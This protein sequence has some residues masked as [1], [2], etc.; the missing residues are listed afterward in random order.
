MQLRTLLTA[1][2]VNTAIK[3]YVQKRLANAEIGTIR[4]T[5][6]NGEYNNRGTA[7]EAEVFLSEKKA[8]AAVHEEVLDTYA[9]AAADPE[10]MAEERD[11][12]R[13]WDVTAGDG[14]ES[15]DE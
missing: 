12:A 9:E 3:E 13:V 14:L 5:L 15:S 10:Y 1:E 4:Y 11:R 6:D 8:R 7:V 2:D